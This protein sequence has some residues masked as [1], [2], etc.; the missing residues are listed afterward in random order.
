MWSRN[1]LS[2][3]A[4]VSLYIATNC[5]NVVFMTVCIYR[6]IHTT[7]FYWPNTTGM[8]HLKVR[9]WLHKR[10][11]LVPVL[12]QSNPLQVLPT[13]FLKTHFA[14]IIPSTPWSSVWSLSLKFFHHTQSA[15][16]FPP[17]TCYVPSHLIFLTHITCL[18]V[19]KWCNKRVD[20]KSKIFEVSVANKCTTILLQCLTHTHHLGIDTQLFALS[21]LFVYMVWRWPRTGLSV[22]TALAAVSTAL[23]YD[24]TVSRNLSNYFIFGIS[25]VWTMSI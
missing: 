5:N 24:V 17:H 20:I 7:A 12:S 22:L 3:L 13:Y 4:E 15:T 14:I 16:L 2:S 8:T 10:P 6:Y 23:R 21:P 1:E 11:P 25:W 18:T 19:F 9:Y